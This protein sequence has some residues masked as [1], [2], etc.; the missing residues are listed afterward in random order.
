[1]PILEYLDQYN[2]TCRV[3]RVTRMTSSSSDDWIYWH[4]LS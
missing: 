3:V 4:S 2:V 1:M